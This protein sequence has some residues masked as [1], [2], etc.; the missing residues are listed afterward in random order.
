MTGQIQIK[1][2]Q[3][4]LPAWNK[5]CWRGLSCA[6]RM[7][8]GGSNAIKHYHQWITKACQHDDHQN[9]THT[10]EIWV[11]H[12]PMATTRASVTSQ[13]WSLQSPG[14]P[15]EMQHLNFWTSEQPTMEI[16]N[17]VSVT[18]FLFY[19]NMYFNIG[20]KGVRVQLIQAELILPWGQASPPAL[21]AEPRGALLSRGDARVVRQGSTTLHFSWGWP[22]HPHRQGCAERPRSVGRT[23]THWATGKHVGGSNLKSSCVY[24]FPG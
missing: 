14:R 16:F 19:F 5:T 4:H 17:A 13:P 11:L 3:G 10:P 1:H 6:S 8:W 22:P 15:A 2:K 7:V 23:C 21:T 24:V 12:L 9:N 20:V 18:A